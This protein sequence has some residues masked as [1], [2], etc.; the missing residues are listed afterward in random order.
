M[1][2]GGAER[3]V[4]LL[5]NHLSEKGYSVR[6]ITFTGSDN[7]EL[8][9][10][11]KRIKLHK[12][13]LFHSVT[14]N[15]F[16]SLLN[17]YRKAE[18]RPDFIS[19]HI[20]MLA[21]MTIPVAK[22]YGIKI[23]IS[24]H[25]NHSLNNTPIKR[26]LRNYIYPY[27]NA[28]TILTK[29]DIPY[30]KERHKNVWLLPNPSTF[31]PVTDLELQENN[32]NTEKSPKKV[33]LAIG[34][35]N[36]YHHKGFDNLIDIANN[37][38]KEKDDWVLK[39][40]GGGDEGLAM[41]KEKIKLYGL[42]NNIIFTGF[43]TDVKHLIRSSEIF[44]LPSRF[45]GLPMTLLEAMS[46]GACCISYDCV[47]GPSDIITHQIDGLLISDQNKDAM[48]AELIKLMSDSELRKKLS[49]NA[50]SALDK[51]SIENIGNR[52]ISLL[53]SL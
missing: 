43:R 20:N 41:L 46:Q 47:S 14:L 21:Y 29:Y 2:G 50:P 23:I 11:I 37:V 1:S 7:Y 49:Y 32:N 42:E 16:F 26:F 27:A 34:D 53:E 22:I 28:I 31:N 36:R 45:E 18:N 35:L 8:N 52:W 51:F 12:H 40:V 48:T 24:E 33:I 19:S 25:I 44:I 17:F 38:L 39:I 4:S 6:I 13:P 15:G 9:K 10:N 30:F 3:V 5:A